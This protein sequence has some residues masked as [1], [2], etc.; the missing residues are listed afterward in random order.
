MMEQLRRRVR[1]RKLLPAAA[2]FLLAAGLLLWLAPGLAALLRGPADLYALDSA[3]TLEGRYVAAR[4]DIIYDWYAEAVARSAAGREQTLRRS[5]IIPVGASSFMGLDLPAAQLDEAEAVLS[6]TA[7][8]MSG[9]AEALDGSVLVVRGTI[10]R[11][12]EAERQYFLQVAGYDR[13]ATQDQARFLPLVLEAGQIGGR[14]QGVLAAGLAAAA[15]LALAA[16]ALTLRALASRAPTQPAAYLAAAAGPQAPLL[17]PELDRFYRETPPL[18]H[19][20]ANA[21][22]VLCENGAASWLLYANDI[23]W[24]YRTRVGRR[25]G[26]MV[27]ARSPQARGR[28]YGIPAATPAEAER[29]MAR[30]AALLPAAVFGYQPAWEPLYRAD[31]VR[32]AADIRAEQQ[33]QAEEA[34][35]A[36]AAAA[37]TPAAPGGEGA[38]TP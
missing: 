35:P 25:P 24:V 28:R 26:V 27:C 5:Y 33:R 3:A 11:M 6:S 13:Y 16:L 36:G 19:L 37:Q 8:V 9:R 31:P 30:L 4:V 14:S 18:G 22:W 21:R 32:F 29:L 7:A 20:R 38:P 15:V 10:R 34:A 17:A 2:L 23:A 12:D 1:R